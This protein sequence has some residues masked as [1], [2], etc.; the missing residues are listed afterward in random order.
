MTTTVD[1][2]NAIVATMLTIPNV[3]QVHGYER[4]ANQTSKL[5]EIYVTDNQVLGWLVTRASF[6]KTNLGDAIY[7][8]RD[9]WEVRGFMSLQDDAASELLFDALA[10]VVQLKLSNDPTF[11]LCDWLEGYQMDGTFEPV[12]FCGVLCHS[13]T[14]KFSTLHQESSTIEQALDDFNTLFA[15]YDLEPHTTAEEHNKWLQ[16]PAD[17]S[18]TVPD[19]TETIIVQE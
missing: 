9:N 2:R 4:Y 5:K 19:L 15:Q 3:G 6:K 12:M 17:Y 7:M 18:S 16:E 1:I 8:L 14:I 11:G 10:N 13:V